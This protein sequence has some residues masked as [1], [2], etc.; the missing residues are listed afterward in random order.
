MNKSP[1]STSVLS[2]PLSIALHLPGRGHKSL[3]LLMLAGLLLFGSGS[4]REWIVLTVFADSSAQTPPFT[5][6]WTNTGLITTNDIWSSVPGIEGFLGQDITTSTG[7]DPQTLLTT[8][9]VVNDLDVIANQSNT[10]ITNGGVAEFDGIANPTVALQGSG[11][12][13]A[14]YLLIHLNTTGQTNINVAYNL[15]DLDATTDNSIQPVALQFRVGNSGNFTNVAAGF[16]ADATSGPSLATLVTPVSVT[17]PAAADNQPLVQVRILTTNAVGN[18]EWVG[19]DDINITSGPISP[20]PSLTI[21]DVSVTEGN[22]GTTTATFTVTLSV[23]ALAGGVTFD[24]STAD[25]TAMISD[26]DYDA[27]SLIGA[28]IAEG[29]TTY[30]FAVTVNGD[31][32]IEPTETF[33]VNITNIV[34]AT[35]GDVQGQ[36]T[37]INDDVSLTPIHSI[38][39]SGTS[40]PFSGQS[41]ATRGIVTGIKSNGYYIQ[42]PDATNDSDPNT[43]EGIFVF[44]SSAP[45][46][47]ASLGNLVQTTG[48]VS[49]FVPSADLLSPP[50]TELV[51]PTTLVISTGN[52]LPAAIALVVGDTPTNGTIEQLERFEGMRVSVASLT[53]VAPTQGNVTESSATGSSNGVF[54]GVIT[55]VARPFREPGIQANDPVPTGSGVTIPPVPRFDANPERL[56]VDSDGQPGGTALEVTSGATVTGL[57]GPLD[58]SFRTYTI[59]PDPGSMPVVSGNISVTPVPL[60]A[61]NQFTVASFNMQRFFDTTN[62]P[63]TSDV[64]LT[65][66]AFNNRLKKVSLAIRNVIR[67]PDIIGVVEMENLTTL[68]S[69]ATQVNNDAVTAGD[70]DPNYQAY[71]VEGNDIGGIDVGFLVKTT[72]VSVIDV[73]Q[74][75]LT[76]TYIDPNDN[77]PALLNDRPPLLLRATVQPPAGALFPITV[78]V[79]HLRSLSGVDDPVDGNRVRTKRRAQA[80]FLANLIQTRQTNDPNERIISIGDYNAF[81]FNDGLVDSIGT[82]KGVPTPATM[83]ALASSD[84]V[85]PDLTDLIDTAPA[86]QRYS[87][88]FDGNAQALDHELISSNLLPKFAQIVYAR[89]NADFPETFRTDPDRPERISDH[90]IPVV[91]FNSGCTFAVSP[92]VANFSAKIGSGTINITADPGCEWAALESIPWLAFTSATTGNGNGSVNFEIEANPGTV[93]SGIATI[94]GQSVAIR[95]GTNFLDVAPDDIF[96]EFIG[97]ISAAGLTLG[98]NPD[99][100]L[101]CPE[102]AITREQMAAV[103]IRA[104]GNYTPATPAQQDFADVPPTNIFYA[105]IGDMYSRAIT[106]GCDASVVRI[107]CPSNNVTREQM[108]AFVIRALGEFNPPT[109]A[110]QRFVDVPPSNVFYAFI[111]EMAVRGITLGCDANGPKYCPTDFVTR[112]QTA[113]F[114]VRA[115]GL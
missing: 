21:N 8:S 67:T 68:Q 79:N 58:Y 80:E 1:R 70:P 41:V 29:A 47:A 95:Q 11:T 96:Y 101:F 25:N 15:R 57:V 7:T 104:L 75:G 56:R 50:L 64:V 26:S 72:T 83:V 87:Y 52:P 69:V 10:A 2:R 33:F 20:T 85:N 73:T 39:G 49:E 108:A 111:E 94:A 30:L 114:L 54:Y 40:S 35:A 88:S 61:S 115:F 46:A 102:N 77:Q 5:Q 31:V 110:S 13:D 100:T 63:G 45:P 65:T 48:T 12:A 109:P 38:Q 19:V 6:N 60:P 3:L 91:Y 16:V 44:T 24:I 42:E 51:T 78:I 14:P 89:N 28:S 37:I 98:C 107:Y 59:L 53:V 97:K 27:N 4:V 18:D 86:D 36:G 105:F 66:T 34:G 22:A 106:Q 99:G 43:S 82:I 74:F 71:L 90:D 32:V 17:L 76:T 92:L 81:Q 113:A 23:P 93:R 112:G 55:G 103:I 84:L 9:G 62:D